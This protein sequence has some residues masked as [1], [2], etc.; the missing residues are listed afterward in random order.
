MAVNGE[1]IEQV[2]RFKYLGSW[3]TSDERSDMDIKCKIGQV[4]KAFMD[5]RNG[6]RAGKIGLGSRKR[7]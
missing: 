3:I 1:Q 7:L 2:H 4:K 6:M 5:M